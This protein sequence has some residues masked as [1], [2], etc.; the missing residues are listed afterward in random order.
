M[1][2]VIVFPDVEAVVVDFLAEH[3]SAAG[4]TIPVSTRVPSPRP[5]RF[6]RVMRTGGAASSIV[7]DAAQVTVESYGG[8]ESSTVV[9]A[10]FTRGLL[11][12][13]PGRVSAPVI[14]RVDEAGG[15]SN[16]PDPLTAQTRYSQTFVIYTRG[17]TT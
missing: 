15:P 7:T 13:M 1:G 16:F 8:S 5:A 9:L 6:V 14:Y 3:L 2:E 12:S 4:V 11:R 10:Q 17:A